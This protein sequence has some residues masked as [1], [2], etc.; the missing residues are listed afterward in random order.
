MHDIYISCQSFQSFDKP[1]IV[2]VLSAVGELFRPYLSD[3]SIIGEGERF[4]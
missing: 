1:L 3:A 4:W 2:K